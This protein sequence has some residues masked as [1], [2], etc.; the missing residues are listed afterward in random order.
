LE[1]LT[2]ILESAEMLFRKYGIRSVTMSDIAGHLGISKKTLYQ[3][4]TNKNDLIERIMLHYI[5]G[6]K[7]MCLQ[8]SQT[9]LDALDEMLKIGMQVQ[10]NIDDM[11]P[12]LMFDLRK[13]HFPIWQKFEEYRNDFILSLMISNLERGQQEGIYRE[14]MRAD[15]ISRI[16]I[17]TI[18]IFTDEE[19][20]PP[21]EFPRGLVHREFVL[22][23]LYGIVSEKGRELMKGYLQLLQNKSKI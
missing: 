16:H 2:K 8:I 18:Y 23:H 5:S 14:D 22:Y 1:E 6:E 17:G 12:S 21:E 9:A 11:N 13:Y 7:A 4:I 3:F 15:I 10:R 20:L 19:L